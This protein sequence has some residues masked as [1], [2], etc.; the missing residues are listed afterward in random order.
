MFY[1]IFIIAREYLLKMY[2][3]VKVFFTGKS[4]SE[5]PELEIPRNLISG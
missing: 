4:V 1:F 3:S 2:N 5:E